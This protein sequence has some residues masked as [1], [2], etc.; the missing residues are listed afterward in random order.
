VGRLLNPE[1]LFARAAGFGNL[2]FQVRLI[3]FI[4][5]VKKSTDSIDKMCSALQ[6]SGFL[7][8]V[9]CLKMMAL[10]GRNM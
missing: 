5:P 6:R 9:R 2:T 8:K 7:K 3:P 1:I 10:C 4:T